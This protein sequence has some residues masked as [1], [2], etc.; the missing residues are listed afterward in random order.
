MGLFRRPDVTLA[1]TTYN[2][3]NYVEKCLE[4]IANQTFSSRRMEVLCIDDGS[5]DGTVDRARSLLRRL[6]LRGKVLTQENSGGPATGR[7]R[8]ID[9]ASGTYL[10][11]VDVDDY[12]GP[13]A[14]ASMHHLGQKSDADVVVGK[15][16]GVG[17]GVPKVLF[18][19][20][21]E[22][23]N[24]VETPLVD[25]LNVLKMYR[26]EF[27]RAGACRFNP[28]LR[29]AE[30]HPFALAAYARTDRVAVQADTDCYYWV[31]HEDEAGSAQHLTGKVLPVNDFYAY[32]DEVFDVL[33]HLDSQGEKFSAIAHQQYWNRLLSFDV[34]IEMRRKRTPDDRRASIDKLATIMEQRGA[35]THADSYGKKA[36]AMLRALELDDV[37]MIDAV[38]RII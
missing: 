21:K 16:V 15:Y 31:R 30:D 25:S 20:T 22:R 10:F 6:R 19:K 14:L 13:E 17:R 26:T 4:S 18:K 37:A 3:E 12:L 8:A 34:P 35:Q 36:K 29:M 27:V 28:S 1:V 23:T 9:E 33:A 11:F 5:T 24:L 32:F 38:A 7:N 2:A